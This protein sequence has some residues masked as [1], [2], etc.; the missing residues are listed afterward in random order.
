MK[1]GKKVLKKKKLC[2]ASEYSDQ[3]GLLVAKK[4]LC[5]G[6]RVFEGKHPFF[7]MFQYIGYP[8]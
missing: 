4:V 6:G 1:T 7:F 2:S 5:Q 3:K 8:P